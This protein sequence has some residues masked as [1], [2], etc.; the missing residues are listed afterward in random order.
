[1]DRRLE[2][3]SVH[4]ECFHTVC[5]NQPLIDALP[6]LRSYTY[7]HVVD[8]QKLPLSPRFIPLTLFTTIPRIPCNPPIVFPTSLD[9]APR[10]SPTLHPVI[11]I[12]RISLLDC[13]FDKLGFC[14]KCISYTAPMDFRYGLPPV[15]MPWTVRQTPTPPPLYHHHARHLEGSSIYSG[16]YDT[17]L[18][19]TY[20]SKAPHSPS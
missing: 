17:P 15:R 9:V 14:H 18:F 10:S 4:R 7:L 1:M 13:I 5:N 19:C 16:N 3:A 8:P 20:Q 12:Y 11:W 6:T 2:I